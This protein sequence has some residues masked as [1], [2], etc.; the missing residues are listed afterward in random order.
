MDAFRVTYTNSTMTGCYFHLCQ[1]VLRE[2]Q[3]LGPY[4]RTLYG[5]NDEVRGM[6]RCLPPLAHV[7][8]EDV[9]DAFEELATVPEHQEID[10]LL[11]YFEH[12]YIRG[13]RLPGRGH[14]YRSALFAASFLQ[15]TAGSK[16]APKKK[17]S[18]LK[19]RV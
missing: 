2:T 9:L 14:N 16:R 8:V 10:E 4:V 11:T 5:A 6:I 3:E 13:R 17:Y 1:S 12:T 19:E 18:Q 7:P 15:E